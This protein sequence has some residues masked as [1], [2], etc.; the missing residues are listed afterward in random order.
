MTKKLVLRT[1]KADMTS[2]EGFQWPSEGIV[3]APDWDPDPH[4]GHGLHGFLRGEG[5][6]RLADWDADAK[7]LVLEVDADTIVDLQGKVKF[8]RADVV[9][10]GDRLSATSYLQEQGLKGEIIGATSTSGD[11]G[12]SVSGDRGTSTS[13]YRGTSTSGHGGTSTSGDYGTSTSGDYGTSTSGYGGTSTSGHGGTSTSGDYGTSTSGDY[14]TSTSG[15]GGKARAGQGG[16]LRIRYYDGIR[17][18]TAIGYVGEN[19]IEPDTFYC[20]KE[21]KLVK[22]A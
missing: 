7:W 10:V 21:G 8:P 20:V 6:G 9:H 11:L 16:E 19:G 13:G 4:C 12:T 22:Y 17:Y 1:C 18:R 3:E 14:G 5:D 15:Y 2:Y